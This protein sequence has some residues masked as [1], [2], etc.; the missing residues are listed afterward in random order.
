LF[1]ALLTAAPGHAQVAN[2][3]IENRRGVKL[4]ETVVSNTTGCTVQRGCVD[5]RLTG[6]CIKYHNDQWFEFTPR[7]PGRYFINIGSQKCRD[8]Q[9]VQLVVLTG[10]PCQPATY[11]A[12]SCTSLG[13]QDDVFVVLDSLRAGQ[14]YLLNVDGYLKDFCQFTLQVS[15][16]AAGIP[17]MPAPPLRAGALP[18]AN[19]VI[20]LNWTLPDSLAAA[21][22]CRVLRRELHEFRSTERAR[23]AVARN[24][25]GG[26][27]GTY[28][29]TDTLP[30]PG[31]YLY[32]IVA[33]AGP[34]GQPP[35]LLKQQWVAF[36]QLNPLLGHPLPV[37]HLALPLDKYPPKAKLSVVVSNPATGQVLLAKQLIS[38]SGND[39]QNWLPTRKWREAGIEK[40]AVKIIC[41]PL[42]GPFF[43]DRLLLDLPPQAARR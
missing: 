18:A 6:Q 7:R 8:V 15:G 5:E 35:A 13:T 37:T 3:N 26:V 22:H 40:I 19:R 21:P 16:H 2:D 38:R 42:R 14:P 28:A 39:Q 30:G 41:H 9:G 1:F 12:L 27:P 43:T 36:S 11:R 25:L 24:T 10:L 4:E 34:D 33:D 23:V 31:Y 17:A 29:A 20:Q 32:Q